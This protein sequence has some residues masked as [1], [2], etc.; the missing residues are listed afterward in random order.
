[1]SRS[2]IFAPFCV[3]VFFA[4]NEVAIAGF[5]GGAAVRIAG[6]MAGAGVDGGV[7]DGGVPM[8]GPAFCPRCCEIVVPATGGSAQVLPEAVGSLITL[9][10]GILG[11]I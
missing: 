10:R 5:Q 8:A 6:L 9:E 11:A 1:M 2:T 7:T 3:R 4:V